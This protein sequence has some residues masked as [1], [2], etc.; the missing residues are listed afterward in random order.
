MLSAGRN[1]KGKKKRKTHYSTKRKASSTIPSPR[2]KTPSDSC[3]YTR[4]VWI[5]STRRGI[6]R[7]MPLFMPLGRRSDWAL[8]IHSNWERGWRNL[9]Q[10]LSGMAGLRIPFFAIEDAIPVLLDWG[11][12]SLCSCLYESVTS[13]SSFEGNKPP[14]F[15]LA[16]IPPQRSGDKQNQSRLWLFFLGSGIALRSISFCS[17]RSLSET[18]K[19]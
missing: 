16:C 11:K 2:E 18:V 4:S 1:K 12:A 3:T 17:S 6:T 7:V 19:L 13:V 8:S 15:L 10:Y 5:G 9:N 14:N